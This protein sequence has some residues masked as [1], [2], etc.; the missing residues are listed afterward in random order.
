MATGQPDSSPE[1]D[2]PVP[3]GSN[4][5]RYE[6]ILL[7]P[8]GDPL[9]Q[10]VSTRPTTTSLWPSPLMSTIAGVGTILPSW[11]CTICPGGA[12]STQDPSVGT[13]RKMSQTRQPGTRVTGV[14]PAAGPT[15]H[16]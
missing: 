4:A 1:G 14:G 16:A 2:A 8:S 10:V 3:R 11:V 15:S 13:G 7:L 12:F 9:S 5:S 6:V